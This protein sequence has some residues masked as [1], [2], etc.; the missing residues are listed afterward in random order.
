GD[1][2]RAVEAVVARRGEP[3]AGL[4]GAGGGDAEGLVFTSIGE[5]TRAIRVSEDGERG[6][7]EGEQG[8][9]GGVPEAPPVPS[10]IPEPMEME[11]PQP[12][13]P[14]APPASGQWGGWV[15]ADGEGEDDEGEEDAAERTAAAERRHAEREEAARKKREETVALEKDTAMLRSRN[16][17]KGLASALALMR[18]DGTL[19]EAVEW[20]GRTNDVKKAMADGLKQ[21]FTGG[22][23]STRLEQSIEAAL[24]HKD[25][26]GRV[27]APKEAFRRQCHQFHGIFPSKSTQEKRR[28]QVAQEMEKRRRATGTQEGSAVEQLQKVQKKS[29]TPFV[30]LSG[31]IKPGQSRDAGGALDEGIED[32]LVYMPGK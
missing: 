22:R 2:A 3:G 4:P 16:L 31:T 19:Q 15:A 29:A 32:A 13:P 20:G 5:A 18:E 28:R 17:D 12:S 1:A 9:A 26:Y 7:G 10:E 14:P 23:A 25:E 30:V 8:L 11:E 24:Q 27:L 6:A 21:V